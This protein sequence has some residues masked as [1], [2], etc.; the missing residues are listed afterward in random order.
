MGK[1]NH[2][3]GLLSNILVQLSR[4]P[5]ESPLRKEFTGT[6]YDRFLRIRNLLELE[7]GKE[8][9]ESEFREAVYLNPCSVFISDGFCL[10][11]KASTLWTW[12]I[13]K[14]P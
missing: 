8:T 9:V 2:A 14:L 13:G 5:Q 12:S 6:V 7:E 10:Q 1:F 3:A 11:I 4:E